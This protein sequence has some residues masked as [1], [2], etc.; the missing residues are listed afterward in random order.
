[1]KI[2]VL[3]PTFNA[4][5]YLP[6]AIE[7]V[8]RQDYD[9]WEHIGMD[10]GSKDN[11]ISILQNYQHLIWETKPDKGQSDA[12]N[13]AFQKSKGDIILYLNADDELD[14]GLFTRIVKEFER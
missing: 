10:G 3:T 6:R 5:K 14:P 12:M 11:T 8:L 2:S 4:G 9:D 13:K 7:S 1:M